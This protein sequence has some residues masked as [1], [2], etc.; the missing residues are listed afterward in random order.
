MA[1]MVYA[2]RVEEARALLALLKGFDRLIV[3]SV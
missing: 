1:E 3:E 2:S